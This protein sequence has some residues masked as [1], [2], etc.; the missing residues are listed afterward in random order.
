MSRAFFIPNP[1]LTKSHDLPD[2]LTGRP[3][4]TK[5]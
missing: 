4:A 1:F 2:F 5:Y 3:L